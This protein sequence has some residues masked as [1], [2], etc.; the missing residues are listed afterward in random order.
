MSRIRPRTGRRPSGRA[1]RV[2]RH[3]TGR[4]L[5][6]GAAPL[7]IL[8]DYDGT[9]ALTD[10]SDTVMAE[11]VNEAWEL[12]AARYDEGLIGS[13]GLMAYEMSLIRADAAELLATA[14]QQPHD[15]GF[16]PLVRRAQAAGIPVEVVSDGFGF[17]I[18]PALER[19][20]VP[21]LPVITAR[22]TFANG[23]ATI[24]FPNGHPSCFVCGTCKR[25][26]VLAQQAAGRA[27]VFIGDGES[28]R[29]AAGYADVVFAKRSLVPICVANGWPFQRWTEFSEI[30]AWLNETLDAWRRDPGTAAMPRPEPKPFFCGPEVWG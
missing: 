6:P 21:E 29:Y 4:S 7:A 20:G 15:P 5:A 14:A 22:T 25:Q 2:R 24:E 19:L 27:V 12:R 26:R 17:F 28:D 30:H 11:H 23:R 3:P 1:A 13:R 9:I 18:G 8:V 16:V 10:V